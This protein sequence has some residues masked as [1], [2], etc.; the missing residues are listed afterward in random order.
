MI[1]RREALIALAGAGLACTLNT[2]ALADTAVAEGAAAPAG[3]VNVDPERIMQEDLAKLGVHEYSDEGILVF[4]A[5]VDLG[6]APAG[7]RTPKPTELGRQIS[8]SLHRYGNAW[9]H[10]HPDAPAGDVGKL[11]EVLAERDLKSASRSEHP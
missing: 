5:C 6:D 7:D 1:N 4:L 8:E 9:L 2:E 3:T 10:Q 11:I